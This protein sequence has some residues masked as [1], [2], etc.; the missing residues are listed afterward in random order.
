MLAFLGCKALGLAF[1]A[2]FLAV[3][4]AKIDSPEELASR[5]DVI[6]LVLPVEVNLA[7]R[8]SA[9]SLSEIGI[10]S[11]LA[12]NGASLCWQWKRN[13][14]SFVISIQRCFDLSFAGQARLSS[15]KS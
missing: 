10:A 1:E 2:S 4:E 14:I 7:L 11:L 12:P 9:L 6:A 13:Y 8:G 5:S 3:G 15:A